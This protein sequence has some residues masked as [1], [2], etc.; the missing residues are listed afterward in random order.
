[1]RE[2]FN[3]IKTGLKTEVYKGFDRIEL[4]NAVLLA[5]HRY[6]HRLE[7]YDLLYER[8]GNDLRQVVEFLKQVPATEQE[9][10]SYIERW[11]AET[12]TGVFSSPQ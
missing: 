5:Y 6:V 3:E 10:F 8:L 4:N 9:P 11:L 1:V 7:M 12:R 2:D